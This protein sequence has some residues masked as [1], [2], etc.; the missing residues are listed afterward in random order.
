MN[1]CLYA[2]RLPV[3][4]YAIA[5][6]GVTKRHPPRNRLRGHYAQNTPIGDAIRLC[7]RGDFVFQELV[8]GTR[9][10]IYDLEAKAIVSFNTRWPNGYNLASGGFGGRDPLPSTRAKMSVHRRTPEH[11]AHLATARRSPNRLARLAVANRS[12]ERVAREAA[13]ITGRARTAGLKPVTVRTRISRGW[14]EVRA[15]SAPPH[16]KDARSADGKFQAALHGKE[17]EGRLR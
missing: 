16:P 15:L 14:S 5:Y 13:T 4:E 8:R 1:F 17:V 7:G 12:P 10:F 11:L 3:N 9:E 2:I 6:I